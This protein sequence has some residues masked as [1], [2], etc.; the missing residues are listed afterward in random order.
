MTQHHKYLCVHFLFILKCIIRQFNI[1]IKLYWGVLGSWP[2]WCTN[3]FL[4]IY[5]SL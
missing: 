2:K 3:Y 4:C 5:F 1:Y